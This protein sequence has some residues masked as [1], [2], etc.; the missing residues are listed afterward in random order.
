M[1]YHP[2]SDSDWPSPAETPE[3]FR[4]QTAP[5]TTA[6]AA[7]L[8]HGEAGAFMRWPLTTSADGKEG[9]GGG[10]AYMPGHRKGVYTDSRADSL[11][12]AAEWERTL[13]G[14]V[15]PRQRRWGLAGYFDREIVQPVVVC[16]IA[17]CK[18][19]L[20][21]QH[22][23]PAKLLRMIGIVTSYSS[24]AVKLVPFGR[25]P[26]ILR[27]ICTSEREVYRLWR[28]CCPPQHPSRR[29]LRRGRLVQREFS[30]RLRTADPRH[31]Q[32]APRFP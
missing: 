5:A 2:P 12:S 18:Q 26:C 21:H 7:A 10:G 27:S 29:R 24:S 11:G 13:E 20:W 9:G 4:H 17:F 3:L 19:A 25:R 14:A 1:S 8:E 15:R 23:Q 22:K 16:W 31:P 32:S 30:S 6:A 28:C